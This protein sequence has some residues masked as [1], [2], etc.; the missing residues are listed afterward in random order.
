MKMQKGEFPAIRLKLAEPY[1]TNVNNG[2][3]YANK[4]EALKKFMLVDNNGVVNG[5]PFLYNIDD[6]IVGTIT[7]LDLEAKTVTIKRFTIDP[8][9]E[10][11]VVYFSF[12][13]DIGDDNLIHIN[14]VVRAFIDIN[15][16]NK[17]F[18]TETEIT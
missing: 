11:A 18:V 12:I 15:V 3:K 10:D 6:S 5:S 1:D 16:D 17:A 13:A 9:P 4:D 7:G 14:R 8:I 2:L